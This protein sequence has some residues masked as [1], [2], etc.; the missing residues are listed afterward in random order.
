MIK[1]HRDDTS[2]KGKGHWASWPLQTQYFF[3]HFRIKMTAKNDNGH[4]YLCCSGFEIYGN[5][6]RDAIAEMQP[7]VVQCMVEESDLS[8]KMVENQ[9]RESIMKIL[10]T[11]TDLNEDQCNTLYQRLDEKTSIVFG[12]K[13]SQW[14]RDVKN[15][16]YDKWICKCM[17]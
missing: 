7:D 15:V 5:V 8:W 11:I 10:R 3:S 6:K 2:L 1:Q 16:L 13:M 12:R 17:S 9:S 4:S 14:L